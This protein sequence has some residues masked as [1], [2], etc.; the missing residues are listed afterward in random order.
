MVDYASSMAAHPPMRVA[1]SQVLRSL[2]LLAGAAARLRLADPYSETFSTRGA[3]VY[4]SKL[5]VSMGAA[6]RCRPLAPDLVPQYGR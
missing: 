4:G 1:N 6:S 3:A 2:A 5:C